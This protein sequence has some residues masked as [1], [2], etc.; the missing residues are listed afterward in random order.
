MSRLAQSPVLLSISRVIPALKSLL[1]RSD[2]HGDTDKPSAINRKH[3]FLFYHYYSNARWLNQRSD[4]TGLVRLQEAER[5]SITGGPMGPDKPDRPGD[6][7]A[8]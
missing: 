2:T 4:D 7:A 5:A 3:Y 1:N 8:P 6:P